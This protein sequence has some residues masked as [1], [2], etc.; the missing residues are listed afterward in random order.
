MR[1]FD[2]NFCFYS[3]WMLCSV[4]TEGCIT[5]NGGKVWGAGQWYEGQFPFICQSRTTAEMANKV[6]RAALVSDRPSYTTKPHWK[7]RSLKIMVPQAKN[8]FFLSLCCLLQSSGD[9]QGSLL[10]CLS[11]RPD[12][13]EDTCWVMRTIDNSKFYSFCLYC[14]VL[15]L[16]WWVF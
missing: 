4:T 15:S 7:V 6:W 12:K 14:S 16:S 10:C 8:R 3:E 9:I 1:I 2:C 13:Q 5:I 11:V